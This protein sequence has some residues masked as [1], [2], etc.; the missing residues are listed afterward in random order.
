MKIGIV[1]LPNAGKSTLFQAITKKKVAREARPFTT[2][3]PNQ[4][5]VAVPDE[6][7]QKLAQALKPQEVQAAAITFLDIAGLVKGAHQ[8]QGLGNEFLSHI[9]QVDLLVQVVRAFEDPR[10]SHPETSL[11]PERDI[12][13]IN[14]ELRQHDL[15]I[16]SKLNSDNGLGDGQNDEIIK[17]SKELGLLSFKPQILLINLGESQN[18]LKPPVGLKFDIQLDAEVELELQD[19]EPDERIQYRQTLLYTDTLEKLINVCYDKLNLITFYT[20]KGGKILQARPLKKGSSMV[21]AAGAIHT[22][23]AQKF[24][25]AEVIASEKLIKAGSWADARAKG[26]LE[27]KGP[28]HLVNDSEVIE[29]KI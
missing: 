25:R 23:F 19:L 28:E 13:T 3:K 15:K 4:A 5:V 22:D 27:I 9:G 26:W 17:K 11:N 2:I 24:I 18:P 1:G 21:E 7:L 12:K 10:V 29:I 20:I 14:K 6:R 16:L 8:G